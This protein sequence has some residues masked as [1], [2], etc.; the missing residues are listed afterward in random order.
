M[1]L[2]QTPQQAAGAVTRAE[3]VAS[4]CSA[5]Q[6]EQVGKSAPVL[7]TINSLAYAAHSFCQQ[8]PARQGV[9]TRLQHVLKSIAP[10]DSFSTTSSS[11]SPPLTN[12]S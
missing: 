3:E 6:A 5:Q 12:S 2:R 10:A 4:H 11:T 9:D 1:L 8:P 7:P